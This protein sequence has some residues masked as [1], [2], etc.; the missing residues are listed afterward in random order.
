MMG[1]QNQGVVA[2]GFHRACD[3]V[4]QRCGGCARLIRLV[5]ER[6]KRWLDIDAAK[7]K[8]FRGITTATPAARINQRFA[9]ALAFQPGTGAYRLSNPLCIE[10][11]LRG[12]IVEPI[13]DRVA[14][15]WRIGM[16]HQEQVARRAQLV[17]QLTCLVACLHAE[18]ATQEEPGEDQTTGQVELAS[19]RQFT[20]HWHQ[21]TSGMHG[22]SRP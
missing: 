5:E 8:R 17:C 6:R 7:I 16:S 19:H 1:H 21:E 11:A 20:L 13:T 15:P 22:L 4:S 10:I 3:E 9:N 18:T 14:N 2:F 12:A